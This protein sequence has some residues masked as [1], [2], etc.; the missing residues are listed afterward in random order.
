MEFPTLLWSS[1]CLTRQYY[2]PPSNSGSYYY[3]Y[4][5]GHNIV[6]LAL[7]NANYE[8][9]MTY[10]GTNGRVSDGGVIEKT[11]FYK[12]LLNNEL[13]FPI[14]S[15]LPNSTDEKHVSYEAN[16]SRRRVYI[17]EIHNE[18]IFQ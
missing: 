2:I 5:G 16:S 12:K 18:T 6:M 4:K 11:K 14:A 9:L 10:V 8:F 7:V 17:I 15:P 1:V 3:N 13:H